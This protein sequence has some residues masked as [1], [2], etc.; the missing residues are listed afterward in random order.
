MS[1]GIRRLS[2]ALALISCCAGGTAVRAK[3]AR[4]VIYESVPLERLLTNVGRYVAGHPEEAQ[5][6][7]TL[8][9]LHAL[10]FAAAM[11][12]TVGTKRVPGEVVLPLPELQRDPPLDRRA[13]EAGR[14]DDAALRHLAAAVGEYS[15]ATKLAPKDDLYWLGLAWISEQGAPFA[16]RVAALAPG[17]GTEPEWKSRA[18]SAYRRAYSLHLN[19]YLKQEHLGPG[20]ETSITLEAGEGILRLQ[21]A[22]PTPAE[23]VEA[24]KVRVSLKALRDKPRV[25]TPI[26]FSLREATPLREL[27]SDSAPV[28]FD[29]TGDGRPARWPWVKPDTAILVWDPRHTGRIASGRQLFGSVTWWMF[30]RDGYEPL[31]ALD[32]NGDGAL[33]GAELDGLAVWQ[34]RNSDGISGPRE[35]RPLSEAGVLS[36]AVRPE[37]RADGTVSNSRGITLRSGEVVPTY[38]WIPRSAKE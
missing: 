19:D 1:P 5:G 28:R 17:K 38:D 36:I 13:A 11:E 21:P 33:T 30:W 9:R 7:Y 22:K 6:H 34:D 24:D 31:A 32:D 16:G 27:L 25:V 14:P 26:V 18:L 20:G 4:T 3:F 2:W 37:G 15:M 35:V 12:A 8:G 29:L 10:G 23:T